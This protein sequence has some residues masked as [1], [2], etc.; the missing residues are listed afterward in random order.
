MID[1][2]LVKACIELYGSMGMGSNDVYEKDM[3]VPLLDSSRSS[4]IFYFSYLKFF[5]RE[6]YARKADLWMVDD[7]TPEYLI[8]AEKSLH[9]EKERVLSYL[10]PL[11]ELKLM[12]VIEN[13]LLE[14]KKIALIEKD[15][16][17]MRALL[18]NDRVIDLSRMFLLFSRL[19]D[20][21]LSPMADILREHITN[22]GFDVIEARRVRIESSKEKETSHDPQLVKELIALHDKY[23]DMVASQFSGHSLFQ[24]ALRDA[25]SEIVN[26]DVGSVKNADLM[27]S[28]CDQILKTGGEKLGGESEIE[29]YLEKIVQLFSYLSDKD[30]FAE[31][32][33]FV[34]AT[35]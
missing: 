20:G 10:N 1:R 35:L 19:K 22:L 12:S 32:Y 9:A 24:K 11:T 21:G 23:L 31:I 27:S 28:F 17:G 29:D 14:K 2:D 3:E 15:G 5:C 6:Y 16:S 13:E 33:R 18:M 30:I 7:S 26:K 4:H 25:F 8:K 34:T